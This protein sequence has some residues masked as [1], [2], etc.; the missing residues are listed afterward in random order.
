MESDIR[1]DEWAVENIFDRNISLELKLG[2]SVWRLAL[3]VSSPVVLSLVIGFWYQSVT[4]D[5]QTA[6]TI[7]SYVVTAAGGK[8]ATLNAFFWHFLALTF[9]AVLVA[10][11]GLVTAIGDV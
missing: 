6:W 5:V 2:W 8:R 11:M 7:A 10:L 9:L 4:D 3:L 1:W